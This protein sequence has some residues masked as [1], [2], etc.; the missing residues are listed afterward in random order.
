MEREE[1]GG[2]GEMS[3]R[4]EGSD[5]ERREEEGEGHGGEFA[6]Q[7]AVLQS[8]GFLG[9]DCGDGKLRVT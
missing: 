2:D 4:G 1:E 8:F 9:G 7:P 5:Q 3:G 6:V